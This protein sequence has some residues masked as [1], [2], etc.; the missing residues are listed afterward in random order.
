MSLEN[1]WVLP[2]GPQPARYLIVGERPGKEEASR[3]YPFAGKSGDEQRMHLRAAGIYTDKI[4][5]ITNLVWTYKD[6]NP[7]PTPQE[8]KLFEGWLRKEIE[9]TKPEI[10][11]PV[12]RH[13]MR[14]FLGDTYAGAPLS[15]EMVHGLPHHAGCFDPTRKDRGG[16][17]VIFPL[18]HP[19]YG[20]HQSGSDDEGDPKPMIAEGY[21][22][23][24]EFMRN[25]CTWEEDPWKGKEKYSF[26]TG[27]Q[28]RD[29]IQCGQIAKIIGL[30]TEGYPGDPWS[31]QVSSHIGEGYTLWYDEPDFRVGRQ[32]FVD[33]VQSTNP[34]IVMHNAPHDMTICSEMG[35]DL[36]RA[37][38]WDTMYAGYLLR[39]DRVSLQK[40]SYRLCDRMHMDEFEFVVEEEARKKEIKWLNRVLKHP[41]PKLPPR[42]VTEQ[43]GNRKEYKPGSVQ[44]KI[45]RIFKSLEKDPHLNVK[46]RW[47]KPPGNEGYKRKASKELTDMV[48]GSLFGKFPTTT[49]KDVPKEES[50]R[51][52]SR[53]ADAPLRLKKVLDKKLHSM[54]LTSLMQEGMKTIPAIYEI[55]QTGMPGDLE[56]FLE[57]KEHFQERAESIRQH[58]SD[59]Y[60]GGKPFNLKSGPQVGAILQSRGIRGLKRT[61]TGQI[62]T[63]KDAIEHLKYEDKFVEDYF[64]G[65]EYRTLISSFCDPIID[66]LQI[67]PWVRSRI[68]YTRTTS[69]RLA[70]SGEMEGINSKL[71]I[72]NIP[73]RTEEGLKIRKGFIAPD[74]LHFVAADL[75]GIEARLAAH[76]SQDP[77]LMKVFINGEDLYKQMAI[78][79]F[80]LDMSQIDKEMRR[81]SKVITLGLLYD[82]GAKTLMR[83]L[84]D[85]GLKQWTQNDCELFREKF[86]ETCAGYTEWRHREIAKARKLRHVRSE[87]GMYRFLPDLQSRDKWARAEA[88]RHVISHLIQ[89]F[90][91]DMIQRS[92]AWIIP[93]L[94]EMRD[95]GV[96]ARLALQIHDELII[97]CQNSSQT[98]TAVKDLLVEALT[99]QHS[100][101]I[102]VPILAEASSGQ[103]WGDL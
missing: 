83:K 95:S 9:D 19:A 28:L 61:P 43:D 30:D 20:L 18:I 29:M 92:M 26:I 74:G 14:Y 25:P 44:N 65:K 5:R 93:K 55:Q 42:W 67:S 11:I 6:K 45:K 94:W 60:N 35:I 96:E 52:M 63:S 77:F 13:A 51:Y 76:K 72:L 48:E 47:Y 85:Q 89:P 100:F 23:L 53:D 41:W 50:C 99:R 58:I 69:R 3:G 12:G 81:A 49:L 15:I 24:G 36:S 10:V 102:S 4:F 71:N 39:T 101:E 62:A 91:Q 2:R 82:M 57:L 86:F 7:D 75:S 90:A 1:K 38:I 54:D 33:H 56:Y 79:F 21:R 70:A 32:A 88:E 66:R 103:S 80:D 17:A 87:A 98:I 27:T 22:R 34:L 8:I 64:N 97:I 46:K 31:I 59:T 68:K 84:W 73:K 37:R 40:M 78:R 16:G